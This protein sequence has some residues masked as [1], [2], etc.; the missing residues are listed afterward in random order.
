M[1]DS[2]SRVSL[3]FGDK[4]TNRRLFC[5]IRGREVDGFA[6]RVE[7]DAVQIFLPGQ[8]VGGTSFRSQEP[9]EC[10]RYRAEIARHEA[11]IFAPFDAGEFENVWEKAGVR[12]KSPAVRRIHLAIADSILLPICDPSLSSSSWDGCRARVECTKFSW[13]QQPE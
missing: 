7:L 2:S 8:H 6:Q 12:A 11:T 5:V 10:L 9:L 13:C 4:K 1:H 3:E